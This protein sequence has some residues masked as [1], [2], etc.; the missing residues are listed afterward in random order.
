MRIEVYKDSV[1]EPSPAFSSVQYTVDSASVIEAGATVLEARAT[2]PNG[3][4]I[5]YNITGD[6]GSH[7]RRFSINHD[8]VCTLSATHKYLCRNHRS[9]L[10]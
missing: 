3:S 8:S 4:P 10:F 7:V 2:V 6:D 5:W 1:D 9:S